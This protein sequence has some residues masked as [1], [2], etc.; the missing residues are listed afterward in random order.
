MCY[1]VKTSDFEKELSKIKGIE[2]NV[3]KMTTDEVIDMIVHTEMRKCLFPANKFRLINLIYDVNEDNIR[4]LLNL[5]RTLVYSVRNGG[6][7]TSLA[8]ITSCPQKYN[9]RVEYEY[10]GDCLEEW[11]TLFVQAIRYILSLGY[12][13]DILFMICYSAHMDGTKIKEIIYDW[14]GW[15]YDKPGFFILMK[16]ARIR[17]SANSVKQAKL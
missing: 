6:I 5:Y 13:G 4:Y 2:E 7:C 3:D 12:N 1:N 9:L 14:F 10:Y 16:T 15:T 8:F 17:N 11:K